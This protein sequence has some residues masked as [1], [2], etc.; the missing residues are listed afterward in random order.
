MRVAI[1]GALG[2]FSESAA[3]RR[4]PER[5]AG[6]CRDVQDVVTAVREGAADAGI[7]PIENSLIGSVTTT[8]DLLHEAFGDGRLQLTHE[9]LLGNGVWVIEELCFRQGWREF[10]EGAT[11]LALPLL[12]PG[13]SGSPCRAVLMKP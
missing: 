1:Q 3:R 4:G 13:F 6:A 5:V 8:Y 11:F 9:I 7:L 12:V 2:S 10:A